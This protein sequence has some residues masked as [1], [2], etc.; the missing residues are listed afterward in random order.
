MKTIILLLSLICATSCFGASP[1]TPTAY[2]EM[3]YSAAQAKD[4]EQLASLFHPQSL[5]GHRKFVE[6]A[7]MKL[8]KTYGE[9]AVWAV[10]GKSKSEM[11]GL[12]DLDYFRQTMKS[13]LE[14]SDIDARPSPTP[15][16]PIGELVE[17]HVV[18]VLSTQQYSIEEAGKK[19]SM[20]SP[21][22]LTFKKYKEEWKVFSFPYASH[23]VRLYA[24]ELMA[25]SK[26]T[27]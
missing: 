18:Y 7:L 16:K 26:V 14:L 11:S 25:A 2:A 1:S 12:S 23:V 15:P 24:G 17:G 10:V 5:S 21:Q 9:Q 13:A 4:I 6:I 22:T 20:Q 19:F 27:G 8:E 3:F